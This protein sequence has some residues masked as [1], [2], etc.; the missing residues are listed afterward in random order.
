M[1]QFFTSSTSLLGKRL[2]AADFKS[3]SSDGQ[4]PVW[5]IICFSIA[6][7]SAF[8]A[9]S[10]GMYVLWSL[11]S[12]KSATDLSQKSTRQCDDSVS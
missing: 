7:L 10:W 12:A 8:L 9:I 2:Q 5:V 3:S 4:L 11:C 1:T 6:G